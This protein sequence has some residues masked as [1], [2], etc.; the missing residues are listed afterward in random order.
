MF[1]DEIGPEEYQDY[2]F[3]TVHGNYGNEDED[4][5]ELLIKGYRV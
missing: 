1:Y 4:I 3:N 2:V 5:P